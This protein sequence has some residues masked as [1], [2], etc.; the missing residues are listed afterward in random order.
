MSRTKRRFNPHARMITIHPE[1]DGANHHGM[2]FEWMSGRL[3]HMFDEPGTYTKKLTHKVERVAG[4]EEIKE[5]V[6]E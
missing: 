2:G 1:R 3:G 5:R 4:K 6:D